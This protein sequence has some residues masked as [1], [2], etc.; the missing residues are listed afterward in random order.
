[1]TEARFCKPLA[2][3]SDFYAMWAYWK[4]VDPLKLIVFVE[5]Y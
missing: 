3:N 2:C 4:N 1:M 5:I